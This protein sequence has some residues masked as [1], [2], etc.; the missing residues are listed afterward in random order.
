MA[1]SVGRRRFALVA[2]PAAGTLHLPG[3]AGVT[4]FARL[5]GEPLDVSRTD[6]GLSLVV[7]REF[8]GQSL[9]L[10]ILA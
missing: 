5:S 7:P 10:E 3:W 6:A 4:A 8:A 1:V 2:G 9:V